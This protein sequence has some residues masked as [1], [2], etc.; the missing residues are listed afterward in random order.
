MTIKARRGS[1]AV[2]ET[3]LTTVREADGTHG[4][5]GFVHNIDAVSP[6]VT[7]WET[8]W[9]VIE[10]KTKVIHAVELAHRSEGISSNTHAGR[11]CALDTPVPIGD[12]SWSL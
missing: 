11:Q 5:I 10:A 9:L 12:Q 3:V 1:E 6:A 7:T 4:R 8:S 2:I